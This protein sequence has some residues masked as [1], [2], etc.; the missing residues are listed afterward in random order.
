MHNNCASMGAVVAQHKAA[1]VVLLSAASLNVASA[2]SFGNWMFDVADDKSY[3][4]AATSNDSG[5]ILGE[6]CYPEQGSCVWILGLKTSCEKDHTY[7][8]LA[9]TDMGASHLQI[10]CRGLL[11]NN[12]Y[13]Y[14]FT[15]FDD[16]DR[17]VKVG[18]KIGIAIPLEEDQFRVI[19]FALVGATAAIKNMRSA[20]T[21]QNTGRGK[22]KTVTIDQDI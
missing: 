4:Y 8:V 17:L 15:T 6:Y 10:T 5:N 12:L 13:Q 16:I 2:Q 19:R 9:N 14:V 11:S 21:K 1:L 18:S 22:G 7:P 20:A 3:L